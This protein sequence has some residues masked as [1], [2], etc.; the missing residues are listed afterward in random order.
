MIRLFI[1]LLILLPFLALSQT[2][3]DGLISSGA[4]RI[5]DKSTAGTTAILDVVSTT[6]TFLPPRMTTGQRDLISSPGAGSVIYN[7]DSNKLNF[8]DGSVWGE[9]GSGGTGS[10]PA[11]IVV[12]TSDLT[13]SGEQTIDGVLTSST[14]VLVAG[15]TTAS[16]NGLYVTDSGAWTRSTDLDEDGDIVHGMTIYVENGTTN[17]HSV[18]V[19][20]NEGPYTIGS[21]SL[22]FYKLVEGNIESLTLSSTDIANQ[23]KDLSLEAAPES[24]ALY[25]A[26][27]RLWEGEDYTL[28][29]AS[30]VTRITFSGEYVS[31]G[32]RALVEG[33]ILRVKYIIK[34]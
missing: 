31:T 8:Y 16:Q 4:V 14:R 13:L 11:A 17:G 7:L 32:D 34:R 5:G 15:Q 1:G 30:G 24:I 20:N 27:E 28:S 33:D 12:S 26:N 18:W 29:V 19:L 2:R 10:F 6:K 25:Y 21:T 22:N 9:V 23:Y 3:V